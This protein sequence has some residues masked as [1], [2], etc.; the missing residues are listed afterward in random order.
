MTLSLITVAFRL[1]NSKIPQLVAH[2]SASWRR[3]PNGF[4]SLW[5]GSPPNSLVAKCA[6][7]MNRDERR[8][9][10]LLA[11]TG[12]NGTTDAILAAHGVTASMVTSLVRDGLAIAMTEHVRASTRMIE[13]VRVRITAAG[14]RAIE[15][16]AL[17]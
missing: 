4:M 16:Q 2:E 3:S 9:L 8:A 1:L 13:I 7:S 17:E 14:M 12:R 15:G 6:R 5:S 11:D 10:A